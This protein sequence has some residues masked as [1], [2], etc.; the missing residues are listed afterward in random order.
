MSEAVEPAKPGFD[1][2]R[3]NPT[4]EELAVVMAVLQAASESAS[5]QVTSATEPASSWSRN[6]ALLRVPVSPGHGQWGAA[7]RRGLNR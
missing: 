1:V 2:L 3:G 5:N 7:Y 4:P 6:V